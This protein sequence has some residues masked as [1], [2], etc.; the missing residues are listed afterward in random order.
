MEKLYRTILV[1]ITIVLSYTFSTIYCA[2]GDSPSFSLQGIEN[3]RHHWHLE[4]NGIFF[5]QYSAKNITQC[6]T[7]R[8]HFPFPQIAAVDYISNGKNL[9]ATIWLDSPFQQP[10]ASPTVLKEVS[11]LPSSVHDKRTISLH[12]AVEKHTIRESIRKYAFLIHP[13]SV[14]DIGQ[15]YQVAVAWNNTSNTWQRTATESIPSSLQ[16]NN[17]VL[18]QQNYYNLSF[19]PGQNY[20]VVVVM[21]LALLSYP[22][23]Y[24]VIAYALETYN[25]DSVFCKL[26][27]V[28]DVVHIPPPD[29]STSTLPNSIVLLAG[30]SKPV[31]LQAKSN[32]NLQS[33]I[34]LSTDQNSNV[35]LRFEPNKLYVPPFGISSSLIHVNALDNA[36]ANPYTL[37]IKANLSFPIAVTNWLTRDILTNPGTAAIIREANFTVSVRPP[38]GLSEQLNEVWSA[39][40][41]PISGIVGLIAAI[42]GGVGGWLLKHFKSK[43][44]RERIR[45]KHRNI[46]EGQ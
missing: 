36:T 35:R 41:T 20:V 39:W 46:N 14:Y 29:F 22:S 38:L 18:E 33:N 12:L 30:E 15:T 32:T 26:V 10:T 6:S 42:L 8:G 4:N 1:T 44:N 13:D 11:L 19:V 27:D 2:Y 37:P 3:I 9:N 25:E 17:R 40:G 31:E 5:G 7:R 28:T 23:Q 34:S 45:D 16:G 24:S 43:K 21:N